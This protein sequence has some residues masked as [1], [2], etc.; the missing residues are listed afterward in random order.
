MRIIL[1]LLIFSNCLLLRAQHQLKTPSGDGVAVL[2]IVRDG[3]SDHFTPHYKRIK[4]QLERFVQ[5]DYLIQNPEFMG[6]YTIEGIM[7]QMMHALQDP[8]VEIVFP[9]GL[10]ATHLASKLPAALEPV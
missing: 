3:P 5:A 2:G 7:T 9:G 1:L 4:A 6:D 10:I 8:K